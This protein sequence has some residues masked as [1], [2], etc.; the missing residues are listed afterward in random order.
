MVE[1]R[2]YLSK[3]ILTYIGN[4]RALL[5]FIQKYVLKVKKVDSIKK[6]TKRQLEYGKTNLSTFNADFINMLNQ[7]N[8]K[9]NNRLKNINNLDLR[10]EIEKKIN[11]NNYEIEC[12]N[13]R[14]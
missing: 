4:K 9:L 3:Q 7:E 1:D 5:E 11:N 12:A 2:D 10:N 14:R 13:N 6:L 8:Q